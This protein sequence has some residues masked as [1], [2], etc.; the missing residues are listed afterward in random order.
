MPDDEKQRKVIE[1]AQLLILSDQ[2]LKRG[3]QDAVHNL[4]QIARS[5]NSQT[6]YA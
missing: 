1:S 3:R 4:R 2:S 5:T 6:G